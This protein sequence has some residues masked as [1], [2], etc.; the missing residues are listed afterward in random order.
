VTS[1]YEAHDALL[2]DLDGT[3]F[4]G[5]TPI[6]GAVETI[7]RAAA[8]VTIDERRQPDAEA[9]ASYAG[10]LPVFASLSDA[11]APAFRRLRSAS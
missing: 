2:F 5:A 1:L 11:L 9:A 3:L 10:L 8:L 7:E 4:L 6:P